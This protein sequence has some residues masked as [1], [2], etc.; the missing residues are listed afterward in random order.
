MP[1]SEAQKKANAAYNRRQDNIMIRPDKETGARIRAAAAAAGLSVQRFVIDAVL[2]Y[3]GE[4]QPENVQQPERGHSGAV[5]GSDE[6]VIDENEKTP[7]NSSHAAVH[8]P[9]IYKNESHDDETAE[10]LAAFKG[11]S[12][13]K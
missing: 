6:H 13:Q 11:K 4:N 8:T 12:D 1:V 7:Q 10:L 3:M 9:H 2:C 5:S